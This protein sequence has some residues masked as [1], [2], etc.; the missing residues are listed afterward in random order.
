MRCH[1]VQ[2]QDHIDENAI[3]DRLA[4]WLVHHSAGLLIEFG[5]EFW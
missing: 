4:R 2:V 3:L 1:V 5:A